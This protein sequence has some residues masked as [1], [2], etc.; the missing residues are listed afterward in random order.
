MAAI[1]LA[2]GALIGARYR[3]E[4]RL[5]E[6][7]MGVVW[8]AVDLTTGAAVALKLLK[9]ADDPDARRRFVREGRAASAVRHPNVVSIVDVVE[10]D[11]GTPVLVMELLDGESLRDLLSREGALSLSALADIAVPVV[12]AVGAAHAVGI[13]HRDLKPEN[14]F[15]ARGGDARVVKVLDFGIAKLTSLDGEAM[16][17]TG[18]STA[19]V[20]GTPAYMAPE[21]VFGEKDIDHRAD[22]W[23]LGIVLHHCLA[24][25]LPTAGDNVGQV[26]KNVLA[27]PFAPLDQVVPDLPAEV[28]RLVE[29]MLAR[30]RSER[31]DDLREV[32][33][34][35]G[36]FATAPGLP[37]DPPAADLLAGGDAGHATLDPRS[38]ARME[39]VDPLAGTL[40]PGAI[41]TSPRSA[42]AT[43]PRGAIA[44]SPQRAIATSPQGAI[45]T[46][47]QA[48]A[49][50][51]SPGPAELA[52]TGSAELARTGSA[53]LAP[54][55]PAE[56][57]PPLA[58]APARRWPRAALGAAAAIAVLGAGYAAWRWR[59]P[60]ASPLAA[61][62]A[63]I[64]CAILDAS[65]VTGSAGWLGAAAATMVCERARL[66][67]GGRTER[68]LIP[69]E[70]LELS[71]ERV[72]EVPDDP[73][74]APDARAR[75]IAAAQRRAQA[76][77][78]GEVARSSAGF[79]VS[80]ALRRADGTQLAR[81]SGS[82]RDLFAAVRAAMAGLVG[83]AAI[84]NARVLDPGIA[85]WSRTDRVDDALAVLDLTFAYVQNGGGLAEECRAFEQV[86]PRVGELGPEGPWLC[87]H[88]LGRP[89][90]PVDLG[91]PGPSDASRATR[92]R[93]ERTVHQ[94][95]GAGDI[96]FLRE[97]L[98]REKTPRGRSLVAAL[99]SCVLA[100][101]DPREAREL[102]IIAVQ[103]DPK[104][105]DG[106]TCNPWEQRMTM[107][108]NT[109]GTDGGVRAMQAWV[110]WNSY[111]WLE[112]GFRSDGKDPAAL[113]L[114]W[115]AHQLSP[116]DAQIADHLARALLLT[117]DAGAARSVAADLR[118][119]DLA[120]SQLQADMIL[121]RVDASE[122]QFGHALAEARKAGEITAADVG[123]VRAQRFE[124]A[125][126]ALELAVLLGRPTEVADWMVARFLAPEPP[127]LDSNF[128]F[129]PIRTPAIC[130][131]S[132]A[133]EPC[134]ARLHALQP[135]LPGAIT[136]D[137]NNFLV[138]AEAYVRRDH[139]AAARAWRPLL[140]GGALLASTLPDAMVKVFEQT[141]APELAEQVD[142]EVM[143]RAAEFH[144]A[145]LG[146]VRAAQ[147]AQRR[148]DVERARR[149]ATE[150]VQA[151]SR[152][153][154]EVPAVAAMRQLLATLPAR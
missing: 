6:G 35:L 67:L 69:A 77:V 83:D 27:K 58:A 82:A 75:S 8:A 138:G 45:A 61:A 112:T 53:E 150:V 47:P 33:E 19:A 80:L 130:A 143:K 60:S 106:R 120:T 68:A 12:S 10:L 74:A 136:H 29:R 86:A 15:L 95:H 16:R 25:E 59:Q 56:S 11:D 32:L 109:R 132:S 89:L 46:S 92:I 99:A 41:A 22:I 84:P 20:L 102:A 127:L 146:H 151:W 128:A 28:S 62:D 55:A 148:G 39:G 117:G 57:A 34:L 73:Y 154:D 149:L 87:A 72:D 105:P 21:Q 104:N 76:Y 65:G 107:E 134:F 7:G 147:R 126:Q 116:L 30:E 90:P 145:T 91:P 137:T 129:V 141:G 9:A 24:G 140:D 115:R 118:N 100:S 37:F 42:I 122:A 1:E 51:A 125:W 17:S 50:T 23:A 3:L 31:L 153:D 114:L 94:A 121:V 40:P 44:T 139:A 81:S 103:S 113:P 78:D 97:L 98:Q 4:R 101:T 131:L 63:R 110:P 108:R 119:G 49:A 111:A 18:L 13:V 43:S 88:S 79:A 36:R 52:R 14:I 38:S 124:V 96:A 144:G 26:L 135:R 48:A 66:L 70:L 71:V 123:W 5:G 93:I 133:P 64:A 85:A 152:A 142:D 54:P 2:A